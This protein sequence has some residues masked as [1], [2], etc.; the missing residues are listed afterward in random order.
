MDR[1]EF[2]R[3][4]DQRK[5]GMHCLH[6]QDLVVALLVVE[7]G[8]GEVIERVLGSERAMCLRQDV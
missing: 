5:T 6:T 2:F 1:L 7:H 3:F 4:V 8:R